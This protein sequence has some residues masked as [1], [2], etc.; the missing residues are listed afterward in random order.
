MGC[1]AGRSRLGSAR[2]PSESR[3]PLEARPLRE[4]G[5]WGNFS[6]RC[7]IHFERSE[8]PEHQRR[9]GDLERQLT[10]TGHIPV[11]VTIPGDWKRDAEQAAEQERAY[12]L[13]RGLQSERRA[14]RPIRFSSMRR[15]RAALRLDPQH[16]EPAAHRE[17]AAIAQG[18]EWA[19]RS[20]DLDRAEVDRAGTG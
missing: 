9:R 8:Q 2:L 17:P 5:A 3:L 15:K 14:Q 1:A 6:D 7:S 10:G 11:N 16:V 20:P 18:I 12:D 13:A 4:M 19:Q